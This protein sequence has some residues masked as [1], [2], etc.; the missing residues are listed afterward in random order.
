MLDKSVSRDKQM[1][2]LNRREFLTA[3]LGMTLTSLPLTQ[4]FTADATSESTVYQTT[5]LSADG[6]VESVAA[7]KN[8]LTG[9]IAVKLHTGEANGPNILPRDWVKAVLETLPNSTIVETNTLYG[10]DRSNTRTHRQTLKINGWDFSPVDILD[11]DGGVDWSVNNGMHLKSIN[12]GSHLENYDSMLVLTHFKGHAMAGFGG[13][14][15][16]IA[17]GCAT[18]R[19]GK[20]QIHRGWGTGETF[21]ERMTD[22]GKA[23]VDHFNGKIVYVNVLRNMSVDCDCAGTSAATPVARDLGILASTDIL[24]IDQTSLDWVKTLPENERQPLEERIASRQGLRQI[25]AMTELKMGN[26]KYRLVSLD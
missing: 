25:S 18:G 21:L 10:G 16:N 14:L 2:G 26:P 23:I 12:I 19:V 5:K 15:K 22:A 7:V 3:T 1:K 20:E 4:A 6:L 9:H 8:L 11:E 13:S 24:A 17:I